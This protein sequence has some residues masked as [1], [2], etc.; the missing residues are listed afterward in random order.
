MITMGSERLDAVSYI[1]TISTQKVTNNKIVKCLRCNYG[2]L[3]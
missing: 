1:E 3:N 2:T